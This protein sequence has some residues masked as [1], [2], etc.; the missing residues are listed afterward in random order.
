M[1]NPDKIGTPGY[2]LALL[3]LY[4][5]NVQANVMRCTDPWHEEITRTLFY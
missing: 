5:Y 4:H 2:K 1:I 3:R